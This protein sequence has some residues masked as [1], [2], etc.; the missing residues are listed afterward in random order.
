MEQ[1]LN[2]VDPNTGMT[3]AQ[4][5][6]TTLVS[7]A[8][9]VL[10][11]V[12]TFVAVK[13]R[14]VLPAWAAA[15]VDEKNMQTLHSA[16]MTIVRNILLEGKDPKEEMDRV[17]E[18]MKSSAKDAF[19]GALKNRTIGE[20]EGIFKDIAISKIPLGIAEMGAAFDRVDQQPT[21]IE[22]EDI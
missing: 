6:M 5:L 2:T 22:F 18:Y 10:M 20:V 15:Q 17:L 11:S 4:T 7:I 13:L 8:G 21:G 3:L 9:L 12:M 16:A 1:F 14:A 19:V